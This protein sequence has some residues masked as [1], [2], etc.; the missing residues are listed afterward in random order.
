MKQEETAAYSAS[1][2]NLE[3]RIW[4]TNGRYPWSVTNSATG[5]VTSQGEAADPE[6]AMVD[7]AQAAEADWGTVR[8]RDS[9][10][11]DELTQT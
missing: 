7:T 2:R 11:D 9:A 3:L 8:W 1:F 6:S 5:E 4:A 10:E